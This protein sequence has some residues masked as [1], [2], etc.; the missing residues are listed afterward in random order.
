MD[1]NKVQ[2][3][4]RVTQDIELKQTPNG[5][6]VTSFSLA[7]NRNYTDAS[8][9]RQDQTEFHSIV[10]WGKLAEIAGQYLTKGRQVYIE[11]RLQTRNWEAQDGTKRYKTEIVGENLIMLGNKSDNVSYEQGSSSENYSNETPAVKKTTPKVEEEI[12]IEDI[13]F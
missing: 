2:L 8:G 12:S 6:N 9:V 1:L 11:G 7:T 10:L 13:P 4:G 3:I 5:Q